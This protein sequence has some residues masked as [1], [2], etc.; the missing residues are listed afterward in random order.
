MSGRV[1]AMVAAVIVLSFANLAATRPARAEGPHVAQVQT[2]VAYLGTQLTADGGLDAFGSGPDPSTTARAI[3]A[4]GAA[5]LDQAVLAHPETRVTPLDHIIGTAI[6]YTHE[7]GFTDPAHLFPGNAGLAIAAMAAAGTAPR[8]AVS[9]DL[10]GQLE[11][12]LT[13]TGAY[14][15]TASAGYTTGEALPPNQAWA[16]LGLSMAGESVP[17]TA[18]AYLAG[19]QGSDGSWLDGDPDTTGLAI[20]ALMSTGQVSTS[21]PAIVKGLRFLRT[22]Q[23]SNGGWRPAWDTE[24]VNADSTAWAI[25]ALLSC[26]YTLPLT[27]WERA[28]TPDAALA[29]LQQANGSLGG[30]YANAYSTAEGLLGLAQAPLFLTPALR[31]ERGLAWLADNAAAAELAPGLA[32][33]IAAA[34][35]A[36]GYDPRTVT[37]GGGTLMDRVTGQAADYA[38]ASVDQAGK[39][40]LLAAGTGLLPDTLNLNLPALIA[41]AYDPAVGAYGVMTNTYHQAYAL[42]GLAAYKADI[43]AMAPQALIALQQPDGGWKYDLTEADWN[44]TTPDNT[45]LAVQALLAAGVPADAPAVRLALQYLASTRDAQGGW[46]NANATALAVQALIAAGED[47]VEWITSDGHTPF[48]ALAQYGKADGA[49]VWMWQ[50]PFGPPEDNVL[51]TAQALPALAGRSLFDSPTFSLEAHQPVPAGPD[52]DALLVGEPR[53]TLHEGSVQVVLS[54]SGDLDGDATVSPAWI[55]PGMSAWES[56]SAGER[57]PGAVSANLGITRPGCYAVRLLISD[58]DGVQSFGREG[59]IAVVVGQVPPELWLIP[60]S[61]T[62]GRPPIGLHYWWQ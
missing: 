58:P 26:G 35:V 38:G 25:Q 16:I 29:A 47:P 50:S 18:I 24:P 10:V 51:A 61:V 19:I 13:A 3:I 46:T 34:F 5:G 60:S 45:G 36:A 8:I 14:S 15:T 41:A 32:V 40:A 54:V 52:P 22:T 28:S 49:M 11:Q 53:F 57:S 56:M 1:L 59:Q 7:P 42:L 43:P 4:L 33:D 20:V 6:A 12:T 62:G 55:M 37:T 30:Q 27:T 2:A 31:V 21:D 17:A 23:L 39:L 9:V 44:V 48:S